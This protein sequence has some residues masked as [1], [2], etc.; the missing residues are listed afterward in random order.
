M[1]KA[2]IC[3]PM[4]K[5]NLGLNVVNRRPDGYHDLQTVFYAVPVC[6]TLEINEMDDDYPSPFDCDLKVSNMTLDG[7]EQQNLVVKAYKL[8]KEE[9]PNLPRLHAHLWKVIPTQAGMGG[10]SSD[11]AYMLMLL[12]QRYNL[13]LTTRQLLERAT[14]LGADCPFFTLQPSRSCYAEGIG[15]RL[16]QLTLSLEGW[17]IVVVKPPVAVST[18]EA[19]SL[20]TPKEPEEN[21]RLITARPVE[22][23]RDSLVNDFEKSV[24]ALHPEIGDIKQRLY[25]L[26]AVY[27]AMSGSGS[28][29][30]GLFRQPVP[31]PDDASMGGHTIVRQL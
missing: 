8:L 31:L 16:S 30:F 4:A 17:T 26:G 11:A 10:G 7:D 13:K 9:F 3:F 12:N 22:T 20:I 23:W 1:S 29:V 14:L 27:A 6:D 19:F 25:D 18:R 28:A 2:N 15:E 5:I 24:F 21:C